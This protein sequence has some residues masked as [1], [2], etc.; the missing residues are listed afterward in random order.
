M[1]IGDVLW[2]S[3]KFRFADIDFD[4]AATLMEAFRDRVEGFFLRPAERSLDAEDAFAG[5]LVCCAAIEFIA[6]VSGT[7]HPSTWLQAQVAGFQRDQ[8]LAAKFWNYFRD[9][10]A[11]EGRVKSHSQFSG[12]FS[13]EISQMLIADDSVLVVNPRLF[14]NL[15]ELPFIDIAMKWTINKARISRS[16]CD[17]TSR[18]RL[19]QPGHSG[20]QI[21]TTRL[22]RSFEGVEKTLLGLRGGKSPHETAFLVNCR[23][24]LPF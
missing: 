3:P 22:T 8:K 1:R 11:H 14:L 2:F 9:G 20:E 6:T 23:A 13:L 17:V 16:V 19:K 21:C 4:N 10:L 7:E 24:L 5:G 15:L 12:E 18:R